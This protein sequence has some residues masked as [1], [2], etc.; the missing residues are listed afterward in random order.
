MDPITR[1]LFEEVFSGVLARS[2]SYEAINPLDPF[3]RVTTKGLALR[4]GHAS[5]SDIKYGRDVLGPEAELG[6]TVTTG[7]L[8]NIKTRSAMGFL[9]GSQPL[10]YALEQETWRPGDLSYIM[11]NAPAQAAAP[12]NVLFLYETE[13]AERFAYKHGMHP[14]RGKAPFVPVKQMMSEF[15]PDLVAGTTKRQDIIEAAYGRGPAGELLL[16]SARELGKELKD[17]SPAEQVQAFVGAA[18]MRAKE[19]G[20][21][22]MLKFKR[23]LAKYGVTGLSG[24]QDK[25]HDINDPFGL[26]KYMGSVINEIKPGI[27][28]DTVSRALH[29]AGEDNLASMVQTLRGRFGR[30][31][32]QNF[33]VFAKKM[34][35][36]VGMNAN[37][38]AFLLTEKGSL[39]VGLANTPKRYYPLPTEMFGIAQYGGKTAAVRDIIDGRKGLQRFSASQAYFNAFGKGV[40]DFGQGAI[41]IATALE[42][43]HIHATA[44]TAYIPGFGPRAPGVAWKGIKQP[45][46]SRGD[47]SYYRG[48]AEH[49]GT[50]YVGAPAARYQNFFSHLYGAVG[51]I[52]G[53]RPLKNFKQEGLSAIDRDLQNIRRI[54]GIDANLYYGIKPEER[55]VLATRHMRSFLIGQPSQRMLTKGIY[56]ELGKREIYEPYRLATIRR[57]SGFS[58]YQPRV[59]TIATSVGEVVTRRRLAQLHGSPVATNLPGFL[60]VVDPQNK[61]AA[62]HMFGDAGAIRTKRGATLLARRQ[63]V[64]SL[65]LTLTR[66]EAR[67]GFGDILGTRGAS[68]FDQITERTVTGDFKLTGGMFAGRELPEGASFLT[69]ASYQAYTEKLKLGFATNIATDLSSSVLIGGTRMT[70]RQVAGSFMS[71]FGGLGQV[72][73]FITG[74]K[75]LGDIDPTRLQFEHMTGLLGTRGHNSIAEFISKYKSLGG[76]GLRATD[77]GGD[78]QIIAHK[79]NPRSLVRMR[80]ALLS[81]GFTRRQLKGFAY[82]P[83]GMAE[84]FPQL[85]AGMAEELNPEAARLYITSVAERF[86]ESEDVLR[87]T[88]A[89]STRLE[90]LNRV[91]MSMTSRLGI[92]PMQHPA[93][94]QEVE[95]LKQIGVDFKKISGAGAVKA[96]PSEFVNPYMPLKPGFKPARGARTMSL[97]AAR[98]Q[99]VESP[100]GINIR[101]FNRPGM[102][103][104]DLRQTALLSPGREGFFLQ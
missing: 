3:T 64:E 26:G 59:S 50:A 14:G 104:A 84:L 54:P 79:L 46:I 57:L 58:G 33:E 60:A 16:S 52:A 20:E 41:D 56:Q 7:R 18:Y 29:I 44:E 93:F 96:L 92:R 53:R 63:P 6:V 100:T 69:S 80:K 91:A 25:I 28:D 67:R 5:F 47:I 102:D 70:G 35:E 83:G 82:G 97:E 75:N 21:H 55:N 61:L 10:E 73:D 34:F 94:R 65:E 101:M 71:D 17:M 81:M 72:A 85:G 86:K 27:K 1:S 88:K 51:A 95:A 11:K 90:T 24:V 38:L 8:H 49:M 78:A 76:K 19:Q 12:Q 43:G 45:V 87:Q 32:S 9:S 68:I 15:F 42:K 31:Y 74:T 99:Y 77:I 30:D 39:Y 48:V 98:A 23:Y 36:D 89:F 2:S 103:I 22:G 4:F 40:S 66:E 13:F 62:E 37:D